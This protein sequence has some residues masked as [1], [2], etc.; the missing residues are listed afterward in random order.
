MISSIFNTFFYE[1]LYNGLIFLM[2]NV[3]PWADIGI[4]IIIFTIIIK[5]IL[6]PL[7]FKA[8][9]TQVQM[10]EIEPEIKKIKER[11]KN[12]SQTQAVELMNLYKTRGIKPFSGFLLLFL[13]LPIILALYFI[14]LKGG[15]PIVNTEILYSF[16]LKPETINVMFLGL[17]DITQKSLVIAII[18]GITQF[19]H[20]MVSMPKDKNKEKDTKAVKSFKD[21]MMKNMSTQMRYVFPF[22]VFFISYTLSAAVAIYW[23]TSNLFHIFQ[24]IYVRK[25][26]KKEQEIKN[27]EDN[28]NFTETQ[29]SSK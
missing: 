1:P 22:V 20:T 19:F 9:R 15:L 21:E 11:N 26:I 13:Q 28:K 12:N 5:L 16:V 2:T 14:F 7:S 18:A 3:I 24:E 29:K 27:G 8:V 23:A 10:K 6:L 4:A 25:R 17:V